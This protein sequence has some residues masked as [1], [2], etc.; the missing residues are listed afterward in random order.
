[1]QL[2]GKKKNIMLLLFVVPTIFASRRHIV[3]SKINNVLTA[4]LN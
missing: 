4:V 2:I 3:P 1:M